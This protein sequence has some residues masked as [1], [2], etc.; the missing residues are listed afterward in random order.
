MLLVFVGNLGAVPSCCFVVICRGL[1]LGTSGGNRDVWTL[2]GTLVGMVLGDV[3]D[4]VVV[5]TLGGGE[6]RG[7]VTPLEIP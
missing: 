2:V 1:T 5:C 3:G 7:W 4:F 6:L